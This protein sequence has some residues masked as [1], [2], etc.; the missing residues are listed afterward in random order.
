VGNRFDNR[1]YWT[2]LL[3]LHSTTAHI[4]N[5][6]LTTSVLHIS[7]VSLSVSQSRTEL[8]NFMRTQYRSPNRRV[9]FSVA[10]KTR[11][12]QTVARQR[13]IP[14]VHGNVLSE[15]LSSRWSYCSFQASDHNNKSENKLKRLIGNWCRLNRYV[16]NSYSETDLK[17]CPVS[18]SDF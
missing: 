9:L 18:R 17:F 11:V 8:R 6:F 10:V 14:R 5:S 13:S 1:I 7:L 4:L 2:P 16:T 15:A 3:Q 12:H